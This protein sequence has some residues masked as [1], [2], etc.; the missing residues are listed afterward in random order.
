M[1]QEFSA[2]REPMPA[3]PPSIDDMRNELDE[4]RQDFFTHGPFQYI[5]PKRAL[6][7]VIGTAANENHTAESVSRR[8]RSGLLR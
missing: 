8:F 3:Y 4:K 5:G 7:S 2:S 1:P 6:R